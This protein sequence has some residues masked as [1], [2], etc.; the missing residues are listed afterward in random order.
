MI[1]WYH[2]VRKVGDVQIEKQN[3]LDRVGYKLFWERFHEEI[4]NEG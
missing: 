4:I 3:N 1:L 2:Y